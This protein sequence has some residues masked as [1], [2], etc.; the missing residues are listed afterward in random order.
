MSV[1]A[2]TGIVFLCAL[3]MLW[4]SERVMM[5]IFVVALLFQ[6]A[7][8]VKIGL[9]G[10]T[11]GH[12]LLAIPTYRCL[13]DAA[14]R[15]VVLSMLRFPRSGFW[16]ALIC[17]YGAV[18][19][20]FSPRL[21]AGMTLVNPIGVTTYEFS[22]SGVPLGPSSGNVTQSLY[23]VGSTVAY[24]VVAAYSTTAAE[25]K[26]FKSAFYA[27]CILDMALALVD[28]AGFGDLLSIVHNGS[29]VL[30][31]DDVAS[32]MKRIAGAFTEAA[33][34]ATATMGALGFTLRLCL[35][36]VDLRITLAL[37]LVEVV[38]LILST[39]TTAYVAVVAVMLCFYAWMCGRTLR[40]AANPA[41]VTM[42]AL[43]PVCA[44][45]AALAVMLIP[46]AHDT[47]ASL[48]NDIVF[49]KSASSSAIER[50]SWNRQAIAN[51]FD[52][53][54]IGA[55]AGSARTSS[56]PLAVV[57]NLGV[58]GAALY[59]IFLG[60]VLLGRSRHRANSVA[61]HVQGACRWGAFGVL[62]AQTISGTLVDLGI[63]FFALA[64]AG[65]APRVESA[66]RP[67]A[68]GAARA[69]RRLALAGLRLDV[70]RSR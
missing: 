43:V 49:N 11:P 24:L 10:A 17:A 35:G 19:A 60:H 22:P 42:T 26:T 64:G 18:T 47:A 41:T 67:A 58:P 46:A 34:F 62:I 30:H 13:R 28:L 45:A 48:L 15:E 31:L 1:D 20:Y 57:A 37:A 9:F 5:R 52:T 36:N 33:G 39:S 32:G 59:L 53:M 38:L 69:P 4:G 8:A 6:S 40:G 29:Y 14:R 27:Y 25:L 23:M 50:G 55:G 68:A 3:A 7:A 54:G 56:F 63:L 51:A 65:S 70:H 12:F 16:L 21:M 61:W 2:L 44:A 66:T